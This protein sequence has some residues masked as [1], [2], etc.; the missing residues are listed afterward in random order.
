MTN[1]EWG[2]AV[3]K[4]AADIAYEIDKQIIEDLIAVLPPKPTPVEVEWIAYPAHCFTDA[5]VHYGEA[6]GGVGYYKCPA[7]QP[8][9]SSAFYDLDL[10]LRMDEIMDGAPFGCAVCYGQHI[11]EWK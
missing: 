4:V 1:E 2:A 6:G 3:S 7:P 5:K 10:W 11:H 9:K 8:G